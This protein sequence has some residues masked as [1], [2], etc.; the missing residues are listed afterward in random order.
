VLFSVVLQ[1]EGVVE[2]LGLHRVLEDFVLIGLVVGGSFD[3]ILERYSELPL[4]HDVD[5]IRWLSLLVNVLQS[6]ECF[7]FQVVFKLL[8]SSHG[9]SLGLYELLKLGSRKDV[10]GKSSLEE[11]DLFIE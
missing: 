1:V 2:S 11:Q 5:V 4:S 7:L 8:F 3:I 10:E 6:L 9:P